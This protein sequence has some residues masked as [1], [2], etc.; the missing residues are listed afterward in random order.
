MAIERGC[1]TPSCG[2]SGAR[3]CDRC[4]HATQ[5]RPP[6]VGDIIMELLGAPTAAAGVAGV[7]D[8]TAAPIPGARVELPQL[9]LR[10][11]CT[12]RIRLLPP[13]TLLHIT[14]SVRLCMIAATAQCWQAMARGSDDFA[15]LEEGRSKLQQSSVPPGLGA[16]A[17]VAKRLL[18]EDS[19]FEDLL[20]RAQEQIL[21]LRTT[22]KRKKRDAQP[23]PLTRADRARRTAAV[24]AYRKATT[25]LVSAML[26]FEEQEDLTWAKELLP[27]STLRAQA[28]SDTPRPLRV[29][30][31]IGPSPNC[32]TL[33]SQLQAPQALE[34]NTS[35]TCSAC[36]DGFLPTSSTRRSR[37]CSAGSPPV[38]SS[39][40]L[41]LTRTWLCWQRKKNGKPRPIKMR[42]LLRS[43]HAKRLVNQHQ[44]TLRSKVLRMHQWGISLTGACEG[45]CHW[46]D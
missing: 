30:I 15:L 21:I 16:A 29:R 39:A 45:L 32:I 34:R 1:S 13:N 28:C 41:W 31:G 18:W 43:A 33:P 3:V 7:E 20:L 22:G 4:G 8:G 6:A 44:V 24:G 9:Q 25:G 26:S 35:R 17:E 23:E 10:T 5:A 14:S 42:E 19:R 2:R 11:D 40:A 46:R 38:H 12:Q 36:L 27:T 37:R